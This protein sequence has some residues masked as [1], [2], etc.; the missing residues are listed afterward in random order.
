MKHGVQAV[1]LL[2]ARRTDTI[3]CQRDARVEPVRFWCWEYDGFFVYAYGLISVYVK[4]D[5][6]SQ[7]SRS[8]N[9]LVNST[10]A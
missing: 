4:R 8:I 9:V 1:L 7:P 10:E 6:G 5:L 3:A 2:P